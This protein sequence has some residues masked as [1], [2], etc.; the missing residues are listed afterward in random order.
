MKTGTV[1]LF[2][3][4]KG[5]GFIRPDDDAADVF[6]H[7]TGIIMDGFKELRQG[8]RVEFESVTSSRHAG[9]V[10]AHNVSRIR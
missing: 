9:R 5:Y 7:F 10:Q 6:V 8:D 3:N 2:S 4:D 1:E